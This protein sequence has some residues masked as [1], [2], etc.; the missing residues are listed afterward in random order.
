MKK[1]KKR[2]I[3]DNSQKRWMRM[4]GVCRSC[5]TIYGCNQ[6]NNV[7]KKCYSQ[8]LTNKNERIHHLLFAAMRNKTPWIENQ[9]LFIEFM[10][11]FMPLKCVTICPKRLCSLY[12]CV[13]IGVHWVTHDLRRIFKAKSLIHF[14]NL[15]FVRKYR[16]RSEIFSRRGKVLLE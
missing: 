16:G 12:R 5:I 10:H 1:K 4:R 2:K 3:N 7:W 6:I 13:Y 8:W 15:I 9:Q 11:E 14:F